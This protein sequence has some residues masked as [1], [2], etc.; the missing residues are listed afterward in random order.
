MT[1]AHT[2]VSAAYNKKDSKQQQN[3]W[4]H[5]E[6]ASER[7]SE[8]ASKQTSKQISKHHLTNSTVC[9]NVKIKKIVN[10]IHNIA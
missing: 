3:N 7:V 1:L 6:Q 4:T 8:Q 10:G 2:F 9:V 5:A